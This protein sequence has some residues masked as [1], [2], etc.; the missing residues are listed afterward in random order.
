MTKNCIKKFFFIVRFG[1]GFTYCDNF[2]FLGKLLSFFTAVTYG[3]G[4]YFAVD[5]SYSANDNYS[6]PDSN[7][8]KHIY[9]VRVLT[10]VYTLGH[11]GLIIPPSKN[12]YNHTDLFDSVTDNMQHPTLFVV[13][14][15]NQAYPEYLITFRC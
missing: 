8:R 9:V 5:A 11:A 7:G 10:G 13:F 3:K 14:F 15:D 2:V 4:T 6:K 12:P 1:H